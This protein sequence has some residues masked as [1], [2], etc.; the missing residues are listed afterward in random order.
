MQALQRIGD[1]AVQYVLVR[2]FYQELL[3]I[4]DMELPDDFHAV[5]QDGKIEECVLLPFHEVNARLGEPGLF[6]FSSFLVLTD[7]VARHS[8]GVSH[9]SAGG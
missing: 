6:K 8:A 1:L 3:V 9:V 5:C 2:G 4:Y 7:L